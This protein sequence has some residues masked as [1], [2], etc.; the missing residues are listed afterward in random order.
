VWRLIG[1]QT[2]SATSNVEAE[3]TQLKP[4]ADWRQ[5]DGTLQQ[6]LGDG[7]GMKFAATCNEL[8][9]AERRVCS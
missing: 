7:F 2:C 6:K 4:L 9:P 5:V 1:R 3:V 8:A